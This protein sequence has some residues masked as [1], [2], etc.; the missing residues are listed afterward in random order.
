MYEGPTV[1]QPGDLLLCYDS[2]L[3]DGAIDTVEKLGMLRGRNLL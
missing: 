3:L 2:T 1:P